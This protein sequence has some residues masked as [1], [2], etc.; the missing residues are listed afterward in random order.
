MNALPPDLENPTD[1]HRLLRSMLRDFVRDHVEP[2]ADE[3]RGA[4]LHELTPE[5]SAV[6]RLIR[7]PATLSRAA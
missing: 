6:L 5:E 2:Q 4:P 3:P 1:E 7:G